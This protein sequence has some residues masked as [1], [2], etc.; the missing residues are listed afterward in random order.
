MRRFIIFTT[1]TSSISAWRGEP[2]RVARYSPQVHWG[3]PDLAAWLAG[4]LTTR[5]SAALLLVPL[6]SYSGAMAPTIG[7]L[8]ALLGLELDL[9]SFKSPKGDLGPLDGAALAGWEGLKMPE[10]PLVTE[11]EATW[12]Q[13][14]ELLM[15][16]SAPAETGDVASSLGEDTADMLRAFLDTSEPHKAPKAPEDPP[17]AAGSAPVTDYSK[18]GLPKANQLPALALATLERKAAQAGIPWNEQEYIRWAAPAMYANLPH[19]DWLPLLMEV[20]PRVDP[21]NDSNDDDMETE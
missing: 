14:S 4:Q 12:E 21:S 7:H 19:A 18:L 2:K 6:S 11:L 10:H 17:P 9:Q 15:T 16:K 13:L 20:A 3:A 8:G 5:E 1:A